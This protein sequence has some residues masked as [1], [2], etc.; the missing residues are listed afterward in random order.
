MKA[1]NIGWH[2]SD[3]IIRFLLSLVNSA[4][5]EDVSFTEDCSGVEW[6]QV[7]EIARI[8]GLLPLLYDQVKKISEVIIIPD[9][10]LTNWKDIT[11]IS[12]LHEFE[13]YRSLREILYLAKKQHITFIIFKGCVLANL[14]P[15]YSSRAS[16]DTDILIYER[17]RWKAI[18]LLESLGFRKDEETSKE[19]VYSYILDKIQ[20]KI[21]LHF[22][23]WED[24]KSAKIDLL[25]NMDLTREQSLIG[26]NACGMEVTTLGYLEH[27][28]F[29]MFHIIKHFSLQG[30][31]IRY[32]I[33]I[34]LYLTR[35][36]E[37]IDYK[38]FWNKVKVIGYDQ[39]CEN[40]FA[41]CVQYLGMSAEI[42]EGRSK[43]V[44]KN[45]QRLLVDMVNV[46]SANSKINAKWELLDILTPYFTGEQDATNIKDKRK[47]DI[48]FPQSM[49]L[50][51]KYA[52]AKKYKMML[53]IAWVHRF[54]CYLTNWFKHKEDW[55]KA[56]ER[57]E[58]I[59]HRLSLMRSLGLLDGGQK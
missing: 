57:L 5:H 40:F 41:I 55:R 32:L 26:I 36:H 52:Y 35:Y 51:Q 8:N 33:D 45:T 2:M 31:K 53:P 14:Y 28:V 46:G 25:E 9:E 18:K 58:I 48:L 20:Y 13:K 50:S 34:T 24:Y 15:K 10:I 4:I 7:Y 49:Y 44:E 47:I 17:D 21:E 30:V 23:L 38:E 42:M 6:E 19:L 37:Y 39:F 11:F 22:S 43:N 1:Y 27:F 12:M 29:Q 3:K 54:G 16:G 59:E 56:K